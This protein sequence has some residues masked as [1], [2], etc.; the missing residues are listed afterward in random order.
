MLGSAWTGADGLAARSNGA[1]TLSFS[2]GVCTTALEFSGLCS[3]VSTLAFPYSSAQGA[4]LFR[5]PLH[6]EH[7]GG[8]V[9]GALDCPV[10]RGPRHAEEFS[11]LRGGVFAPLVDLD[12]VLL[13]RL[14]QFGLLIGSR[15]AAFATCIPSR[16]R[17]RI[18]SAQTRRPS[19]TH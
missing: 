3:R 15:P 8:N 18:K 14:G 2:E 4:R 1:F 10:E 17:E 9:T 13:L 11:G 6:N 12:Q 7:L 19:P 5:T 16:V